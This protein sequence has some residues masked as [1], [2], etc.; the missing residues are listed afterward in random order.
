MVISNTV[1]SPLD[2]L[3]IITGKC[4]LHGGDCDDIDYIHAILSHE[5]YEDDDCCTVWDYPLTE[6]DE[7]L[8]NEVDVVLVE[9]S[10]FNQNNELKTEYR[11]I[12][13]PDG[14]VEKFKEDQI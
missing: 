14:C 11:W 8:A 12:Q 2:F 1:Y 13:V 4:F 5:G 6:I 9:C 3:E 7:C 10:Y